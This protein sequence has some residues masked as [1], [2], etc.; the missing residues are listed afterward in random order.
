MGF[1]GGIKMKVL[2][3]CLHKGFV[4]T[5]VLEGT[6]GNPKLIEKEKIPVMDTTD[7]PELMNWFDSNF[8]EMIDRYNPDK[9]AFKLFLEPK[10]AQLFYMQFPYGVLNLIC[11]ERGI[12]AVDYVKQNFKATKFGYDKSI[13][14]YDLCD[15]IF[16][17]NP[18][19]WD[20]YQKD[21]L[22]AAWLT[23]PKE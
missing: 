14:A 23:L 4:R 5:C 12:E 13:K 20:S 10:K 2:G 7:A 18:P 8:R 1:I 19:Y 17:K 9:I 16:G 3:I 21:A 6:N 11:H 22:L 15:D